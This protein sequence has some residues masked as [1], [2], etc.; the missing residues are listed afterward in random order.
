MRLQ[1]ITFALL[2][3][4]TPLAAQA[5]EGTVTMNIVRDD[6]QSHSMSFLLKG[7]KIRMDPVG[8]PVSV[9]MDPVADHMIVIMNAQRMYMERDFP[10][11]MSSVQQQAAGKN[12]AIVHTGKTEMVAGYKCEHVTITDDDGQE[13]DACMSSELGGF[14][15]PAA[16]NPMS[17]QKEAGWLSQVGATS[18]PLKVMKGGKTVMVVSAI[19]RK[20]LDPALFV[21]PEGYQSFAMPR[22][23]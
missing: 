11:A 5:F 14:R 4:A 7:G 22:R 19:E 12:P 1:T 10:G 21:A 16:S 6:G 3:S 23:P 18:F 9:I 2:C 13:V 17:P 8:T 20:A 15:L